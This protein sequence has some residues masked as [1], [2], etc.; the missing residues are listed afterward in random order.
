MRDEFF[1]MYQQ[2]KYSYYYYQSYG[3]RSGRADTVITIFLLLSSIGVIGSWWIWQQL[4]YLWGGLLGVAQVLSAIQSFLPF[5]KRKASSQYICSDLVFLINEIEKDWH[6]IYIGQVSEQKIALL[7]QKH[8][9][10]YTKIE[11][12]YSTATLFP[13]SKKH[14][15]WASQ[16]LKEFM[17]VTYPIEQEVS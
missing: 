5:N 13:P 2:Y 9:D 1:W 12:K 8:Q 11:Q 7:I 4:P 14:K 10:S 15:K 16:K 17:E 6:L 3:I